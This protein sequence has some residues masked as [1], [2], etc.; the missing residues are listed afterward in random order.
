MISETF[1]TIIAYVVVVLGTVTLTCLLLYALI[2][3]A[4]E[5]WGLYL[6]VRGIYGLFIQFLLEHPKRPSSNKEDS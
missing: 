5:L 1:K 4:G 6:K 3:S 2:W